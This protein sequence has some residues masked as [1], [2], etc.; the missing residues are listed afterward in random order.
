MGL[1]S[2][3]QSNPQPGRR[4]APTEGR[5]EQQRLTDI[6]QRYN[7]RRNRTLTGSRSSEIASAGEA[8]AQLKSP[9]VQA[10]ELRKKRRR[11]GSLLLVVLFAAMG[12][13]VLVYEFT[14]S[15][16]V[17]TPGI[18]VPVDK[19]YADTI[20]SYLV[21]RPVERLRFL[22]NS[23]A[24]NEYVKQKLPEVA[25]V[26]VGNNSGFGRSD[27]TIAMRQPLAGWSIQGRQQYVDSSGTAFSHNYYPTPSVQIVDNSGVQAAGGQAI[28]SNR[29]LSFVGRTV[30]LTKAQG[31]TVT[32][33]AIPTGTT[34]EVELH[35]DGL[36][37]PIK[38]SIDRGVG[39]QVEDMVRAI[40]WFQQ[41][42][43][44]PQYIDIRV[45]GKAF[46]R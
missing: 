19:S 37:Y 41:K 34:R 22:T 13:C 10:H 8:N 2:K 33:V 9:R 44:S 31:Y 15:V 7:F 29:F 46:Y 38:L 32:Q 28:A 36:A 3:K 45:S 24:L 21:T 4:A 23:D 5:S 1:F 17:R 39:E 43:Q 27:Y 30:G 14:A 40:H 6:D 12:L 25:S 26:R 42:K 18:D 11:L 20:Q 35:I 16:D